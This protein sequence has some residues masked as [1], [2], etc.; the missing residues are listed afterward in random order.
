MWGSGT[1]LQCTEGENIAK[2]SHFMTC[3]QTL[4]WENRFIWGHFLTTER[5]I[6]HCLTFHFYTSSAMLWWSFS[7]L[8]SVAK[9]MASCVK[10]RF[11]SNSE[12]N[13]DTFPFAVS[14]FLCRMI[15]LL[16]GCWNG[17]SWKHRVVGGRVFLDSKR[18]FY[19]Q[20]TSLTARRDLTSVLPWLT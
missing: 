19:S 17:R 8:R 20:E 5:L 12:L 3:R 14:L 7:F 4:G 2:R 18:D 13:E 6:S 11:T 9:H 10:L 1:S 16:Q 15:C